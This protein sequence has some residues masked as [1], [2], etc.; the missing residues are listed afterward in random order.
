MSPLPLRHPS[1]KCQPDAGRTPPLTP[2]FSLNAMALACTLAVALP[3][4]SPHAHAQG[5]AATASTASLSLPAQPLSQTLGAIARQF[6]TSIGADGA[7]LEGRTAP[8]LQGVLTLQQ[9]LG[10]SLAG[11]GLTFLRSSATAITVVRANTGDTSSLP[12]VTVTAAV[13]QETPTSRVNGYVARRSATATKTDTLLIESPQSV[14]VITSDEIGD[15]KAES[16]D[17]VLRYTAGVT[18]NMKSWAVDEFSLLRGF[19]LGTAG[20][21][22]DG[23]L[24]S[25]RA[26]AAPIEPYGL[27]RLEVLRGPASVL[28][29]QSPPGGMVNAVSKRPTPDVLREIGV[30]FGSYNR[31]QVKVDLGGPLDSQGVWTYR[32]TMLGRDANTR[33]DHDKDNRLYIAP[34]LTWQ[35]N[36]DTKLTLL[37]RYQKDNQQYAWQN[38]LQN[39][40][41]LGQVDPS[42]SVGGHD[43]RWKRHNKMLGYEFEHRFD[44]VWSVQQNL[45]YSEFDRSETNIFPRALESD[46]RSLTR[47]FSPRETH[48]RGWLADTRLQAR[49]QTGPVEHKVLVGMDYAR[50]RTLNEYLYQTPNI[51]PIDL[52]APD[53]SQ[54][55]QVVAA[56]DPEVN[57]LPATQIGWYVQDQLKW[58]RLVVTAG[59]RHDRSDA[60]GTISRPASGTS[61]RAYDQSSSATTG[62]LGAVYL[63]D[64]GWAPYVSYSTSFTPE[65]GR[66]VTGDTLKPSKGRQVEAGVRYQP[67]GSNAS[68]T[69]AVFDLV[70]HNVTTPAPQDRNELVQTGKV[71]SRGVELEARTNLTRQISVI[72]QYTY[73][74]TEIQQSNNGDQGLGLES[75]P[76]H[77]ASVWG[78]YTFPVGASAKAFAAVGVRHLGKA[79]SAF[80]SN[81]TNIMDPRLTLVDAALGFEQGPWRL[82]LNVNNLFDKQALTDCNGSL[83]YRSA[84]RT[85]TVSAMYRF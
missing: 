19:S 55:P 17:E 85:A 32:L 16:L 60:S 22:L 4:S 25:G 80:D 70:R 56:A 76:R 44:D 58:Q 20:I 12:A 3:L 37:A 8:A 10:Q 7:L 48:W 68:Y 64:S 74:D 47:R 13:E 84:E 83:C 52:F 5:P 46:G 29:G 45:R 49:L 34:A 11:S 18:P 57:K 39:P 35:P 14:S 28:Y 36:A 67:A 66:S 72:A 15:R 38:Q 79:R 75:A 9:A 41:A 59:L 73:L 26:Y 65:V 43:N 23:L 2:G 81:N 31:K 82:S 40:G 51:A 77:N 63:F 53:Y 24:T 71:S 54:R 6:G 1:A 61:T 69:V 50:S 30:E 33:L 62:R 27:E 21:F 42:V 78:K